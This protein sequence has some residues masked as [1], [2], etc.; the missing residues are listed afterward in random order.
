VLAG[1]AAKAAPHSLGSIDQP[2]RSGALRVGLIFL[3]TPSAAQLL[4]LGI[5]WAKRT[6]HAF[7]V[8]PFGTVLL[9]R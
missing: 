6:P 9:V 3:S 7:P 1:Q 8:P 5:H 2:S 4:R